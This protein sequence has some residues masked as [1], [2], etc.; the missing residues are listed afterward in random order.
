MWL[1][2]SKVQL[3]LLAPSAGV[4]EIEQTYS[5]LQ[6]LAMM[7]KWWSP[8]GYQAHSTWVFWLQSQS[9]TLLHHN[10]FKCHLNQAFSMNVWSLFI[11]IFANYFP[12]VENYSHLFLLSWSKHVHCKIIW[13]YVMACCTYILYIHHISRLQW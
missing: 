8:T 6:P 2:E 11:R 4:P 7:L 10:N 9:I 1:N 5:S 12:N 3:Q 13:K